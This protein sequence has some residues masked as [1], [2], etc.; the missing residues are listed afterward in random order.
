ME[1]DPDGA[2][3]PP[4]PGVARPTEDKLKAHT[5]TQRE[6]CIY[7]SREKTFC[8]ISLP[9]HETCCVYVS[10]PCVWIMSTEPF[11]FDVCAI[12]LILATILYSFDDEHR[13]RSQRKKKKRENRKRGL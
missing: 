5:H 12:N 4:F 3:A 10:L 13:Q 1:S 9:T 8:V 11:G 2:R 7:C 6:M